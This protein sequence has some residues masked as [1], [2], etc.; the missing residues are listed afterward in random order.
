[1]DTVIQTTYSLYQKNT[2]VVIIAADAKPDRLA[3]QAAGAVAVITNIFECKKMA[4][5]IQ[6]AAMMIPPVITNWQTRFVN[7]M[8]WSPVK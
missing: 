2:A 5:I 1:L 4:S 8:P 3:Y 7:R 6:R